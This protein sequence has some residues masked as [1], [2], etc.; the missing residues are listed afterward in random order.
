[1]DAQ[2]DLAPITLV[3][4]APNVLVIH[5][6]LPAKT[7]K[8]LI[9]LAKSHPGALNFSSG[10]TGSSSHLAAELFKYLAKVNIVRVSYKSGAQETNDL[11]AGQVQ[12]TFSTPAQ[13]MQYVNPGRLRAIAV[14]SERASPLVP[15]LPPIAATLP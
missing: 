12:M 14:T 10:G 8:E 15:G 4:G 3:G 5:P 11:I 9:A 2:R 13:V 6:A 1:Y 7:V